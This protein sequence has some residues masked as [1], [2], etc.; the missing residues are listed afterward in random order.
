MDDERYQLHDRLAKAMFNANAAYR[1]FKGMHHIAFSTFYQFMKKPEL[2]RDKTVASVRLACE[3]LEA[4]CLRRL[5][6]LPREKVKDK[7]EIIAKLY[8]QW[9]INNK[10]FPLSTQIEV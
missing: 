7:Q 1:D 6:P 5:L 9:W 3:F 8:E 2:A 4:A 10:H